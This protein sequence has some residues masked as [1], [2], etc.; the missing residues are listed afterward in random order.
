MQYTIWTGLILFVLGLLI[1]SFTS[2]VSA[3]GS[4]HV[5]SADKVAQIS[6]LIFLQGVCLGIGGGMMYAP[7]LSL[8][9]EWFVMRRG[10]ASGIMFAGGGVGGKFLD[11]VHHTLPSLTFL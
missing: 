10:L 9:P 6:V 2:Q 5:L 7:S 3:C 11:Y 1:S 8:L 4:F